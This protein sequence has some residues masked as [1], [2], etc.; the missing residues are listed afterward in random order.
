M[1]SNGPRPVEPVFNKQIIVE[2]LPVLGKSRF[3]PSR[4]CG[5]GNIAISS[6]VGNHP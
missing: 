3:S 6:G 4:G 1:D 2:H 5:T